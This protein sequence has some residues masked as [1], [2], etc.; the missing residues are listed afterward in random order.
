MA[1]VKHIVIMKFR[2]EVTPEQIDSLFGII[3][4]LQDRIPGIAD[5]CGGR[6]S[7]PE[8][9]NRGFTHGFIMTFRDE[10]ARDKYLQHPDHMS[11]AQTLVPLIAESV[12]FDFAVS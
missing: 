2:P 9:F 5:V 10:V 3:Y 11:A 6:Y 12:A 7:S 8:G 1:N 4:S